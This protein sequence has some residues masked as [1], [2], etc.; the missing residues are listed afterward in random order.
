MKTCPNCGAEC[1][2]AAVLCTSCGEKLI[3]E[4]KQKSLKILNG[5]KLTIIQI[6]LFVVGLLVL[7]IFRQEALFSL[8]II[9]TAF[10][11][12][13]S[14]G[15]VIYG[16]HK[17]MDNLKA[18]LL[19]LLALFNV[20]MQMVDSACDSDIRFVF[21]I[22]AILF[23]LVPAFGVMGNIMKKEKL[24]LIFRVLSVF[25]ALFDLIYLAINWFQKAYTDSWFVDYAY[26]SYLYHH[27]DWELLAPALI[28]HFLSASIFVFI[29]FT[30]KKR[31][32]DDMKI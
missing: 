29:A 3:Q 14:M 8:G 11:L 2:D 23:P 9:S 30:D 25:F 19:G 4:R 17:G 1:V 18:L 13:A 31:K 24:N 15:I 22:G 16:T 5:K 28:F 7:T 27:T 26:G 21:L 6:A 10:M 20:V 12:I 32:S